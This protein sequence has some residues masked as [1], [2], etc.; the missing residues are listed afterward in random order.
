MGSARPISRMEAAEPHPER[1][2]GAAPPGV[3]VVDVVGLADGAE[4]VEDGGIYE[5]GELGGDL[6]ALGAE[7]V[8]VELEVVRDAGDEEGGTPGGLVGGGVGAA[9][10]ILA[11]DEVD[12]AGAALAVVDALGGDDDVVE[13]VSALDFAEE[14][15]FELALAVEAFAEV[16]DGVIGIAGAD[17]RDGDADDD[18][19]H[20][21][22]PMS[23]AFPLH[24]SIQG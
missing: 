22:V 16:A 9:V 17:G 3:G 8:S 19:D 24:S 12:E 13:L 20:E 7:L 5:G 6:R 1:V 10:P 2:G 4:E 11:A 21:P 23:D 15:L 14:G 18:G